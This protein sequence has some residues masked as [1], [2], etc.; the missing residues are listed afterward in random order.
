MQYPDAFRKD[1]SRFTR[2]FV[3]VGRAAA[4]LVNKLVPGKKNAHLLLVANRRTKEPLPLGV[5]GE[6]IFVPEKGTDLN[7]WTPR[8]SPI[9]IL[10]EGPRFLFVGRLPWKRL[11]IVLR[12]L[13]RLP[14]ATLKVIGDDPMRTNWSALTESL[15]VSTRVESGGWLPQ[16][17]S[18]QHQE[19]IA[20]LPSIF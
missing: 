4:N 1:E 7:G 20:L 12:A 5:R 19:A 14:G 16:Q 11:D 9:S 3:A 13:T 2:V 10:R 17:E 8:Q 18:A 6:V 15:N